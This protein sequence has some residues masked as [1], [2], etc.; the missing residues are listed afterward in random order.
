MN[1]CLGDYLPCAWC[2]SMGYTD[3]RQE[4]EGGY[5][6]VRCA[7]PDIDWSKIGVQVK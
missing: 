3:Q 4:V 6:C 5:I 7:R 1:S 2:G